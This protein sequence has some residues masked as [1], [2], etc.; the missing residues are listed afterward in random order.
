MLQEQERLRQEQLEKEMLERERGLFEEKQRVEEENRR[1]EELQREQQKQ[2]Q[3]HQQFLEQ[4]NQMMLLQNQQQMQDFAP[5]PTYNVGIG[6]PSDGQGLYPQS[7]TAPITSVPQDVPASVMSNEGSGVGGL[8]DFAMWDAAGCNPPEHAPVVSS[9][10]YPAPPHVPFAPAAVQA[11]PPHPEPV[12]HEGFSA[13][14]HVSS[15]LLSLLTPDV[16]VAMFRRLHH[17]KPRSFAHQPH[18]LGNMSYLRETFEA[19]VGNG[20]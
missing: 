15:P 16:A 1:R 5:Q 4:Q 19:E 9:G 17:R 6:A 12:S 11:P 18:M 13:D 20:G 8:I 2:Q 14:H 3:Q 10:Q 7:A